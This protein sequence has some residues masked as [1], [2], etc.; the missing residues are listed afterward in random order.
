MKF[1]DLI[2]EVEAMLKALRVPCRKVAVI[3]HVSQQF[4]CEMFGLIVSVTTEADLDY[5]KEAAMSKMPNFRYYFITNISNAM[6]ARQTLIWALAE[7]GYLGFIRT[8]FP[9]QFADLLTMQDF[10]KKIIEER[11][12]RW[13]NLPKYKFLIE[14]NEKARQISANVILAVEPGFF[15]YMPEK[16]EGGIYYAF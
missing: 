2:K 4:I 11:L 12:K 5:V 3:K 14:E 16:E 1:E 15:D 6:D 9:R 13:N 10:G 8:N 7:G